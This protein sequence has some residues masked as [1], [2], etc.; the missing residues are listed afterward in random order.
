MF[1]HSKIMP[2]SLGYFQPLVVF[3]FEWN[4]FFLNHSVTGLNVELKRAKIVHN[5]ANMWA[6]LIY[7]PKNLKIR[8]NI[9]LSK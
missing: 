9:Y 3:Y 1:I 2:F 6:W 7:L 4:I 8:T 5:L